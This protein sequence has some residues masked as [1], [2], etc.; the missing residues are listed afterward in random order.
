ML[1]KSLFSNNEEK[2]A[3]LG[4]S[5]GDCF[6]ILKDMVR[7]GKSSFWRLSKQQVDLMTWH[8]NHLLICLRLARLDGFAVSISLSV[9]AVLWVD[10][11]GLW[12]RQ[13]RFQD[14]VVEHRRHHWSDGGI[15]VGQTLLN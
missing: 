9:A 11:G 7:L 10:G 2:S 12:G 4:Q 1:S 8:L 5:M 15:V 3:Y 6:D 13:L 14:V